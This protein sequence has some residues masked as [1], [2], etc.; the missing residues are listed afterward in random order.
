M[1]GHTGCVNCIEWNQNGTYVYIFY[2]IFIIIFLELNYYLY[3]N[4]LLASGSDDQSIIL[5]DAFNHR[6]LLSHPT[7][8]MGNI[9]SVK[10]VFLYK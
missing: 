2:Q 9:F 1:Q 7:G 3:T 6:K 10:V 8:H 4:R 5:W